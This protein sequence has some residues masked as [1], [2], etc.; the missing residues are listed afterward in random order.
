M[1]SQ[2]NYFEVVFVLVGFI[3]NIVLVVAVQ[4]QLSCGQ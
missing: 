4:I 2:P 1:R 3:V